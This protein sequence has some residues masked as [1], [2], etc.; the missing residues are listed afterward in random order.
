MSTTDNQHMNEDDDEDDDDDDKD[1]SENT[2]SKK[3][4]TGRPQPP[5]N[6]ERLKAF[7]VCMS[8]ILKRYFSTCSILIL[9]KYCCCFLYTFTVVYFKYVYFCIKDA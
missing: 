6:P 5:V 1:E 7:N 4:T 9:V 8:N 2:L 3:D